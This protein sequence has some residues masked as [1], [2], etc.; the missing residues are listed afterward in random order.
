MLPHN[1]QFVFV[2]WR[3]EL[4]KVGPIC[5]ELS[6]VRFCGYSSKLHLLHVYIIPVLTVTKIASSSC[7]KLLFRRS[8]SAC[9]LYSAC[10]N[11]GGVRARAGVFAC[12]RQNKFIPIKEHE[13]E[14]LF[15]ACV[16]E[17]LYR[18]CTQAVLSLSFYLYPTFS[19]CPS[20]PHSL[21]V[22]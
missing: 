22:S 10:W 11:R 18:V 3:G 19:L 8:P 17:G 4:S 12:E 1:R 21:S 6:F 7:D 16:T 20:P 14:K 5:I 2:C 9:L 15:C 13:I